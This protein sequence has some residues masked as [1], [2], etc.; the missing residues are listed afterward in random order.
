MW[1]GSQA[2]NGS[3]VSRAFLVGLAAAVALEF[4]TEW[5]SENKML[6]GAGAAVFALVFFASSAQGVGQDV[7]EGSDGKRGR[8]KSA[9]TRRAPSTGRSGRSPGKRGAKRKQEEELS[10]DK[11]DSPEAMI[12]KVCEARGLEFVEV[13]K[14]NAHEIHRKLR[15][16]GTLKKITESRLQGRFVYD[17]FSCIAGE[18]LPGSSKLGGRKPGKAEY[19]RGGN[20]FWSGIK[21]RVLRNTNKW[22][23]I[24]GLYV[25]HDAYLSSYPGPT[26][27]FHSCNPMIFKSNNRSQDLASEFEDKSQGDDVVG[28]SLWCDIPILAGPGSGSVLLAHALLSASKSRSMGV[29]SKFMVSV[30]GGDDN[31][32]MVRL[33]VRFGFSR[34]LMQHP[35]DRSGWLDEAGDELFVLWKKG[36]LSRQSAS[37]LLKR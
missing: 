9:R 4:C 11:E 32:R 28:S 12:D 22:G 19:K 20:F 16:N 30:A 25:Y 35:E 33:L 21:L 23:T 8:K 37:K 24:R 26:E 13:T 3:T 18:F 15:N 17:F 29:D 5:P 36:P 1:P 2:V 27:F 31:E 6:G 7:R 34:L 14:K 10:F